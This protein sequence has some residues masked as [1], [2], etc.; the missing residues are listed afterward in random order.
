MFQV[1]KNLVINNREVTLVLTTQNEFVQ[2][3]FIGDHESLTGPHNPKRWLSQ[4]GA[5]RTARNIPGCEV[6][7]VTLSVGVA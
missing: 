7:E 2:E 3:R 4:Y 6:A 5:E 1:V